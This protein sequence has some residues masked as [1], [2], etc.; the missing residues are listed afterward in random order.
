MFKLARSLLRQRVTAEGNTSRVESNDRHL[1]LHFMSHGTRP[2]Q[3][4][5]AEMIDELGRQWI[6]LDEESHV[7]RAVERIQQ[8]IP[9][10]TPAQFPSRN[11]ALRAIRHLDEIPKLPGYLYHEVRGQAGQ[12][13]GMARGGFGSPTIFVDRTDMYFGND[14]L[15]LV[16]EALMRRKAS[17]A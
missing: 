10:D 12:A 5:F 11:G 3:Y 15:P 16:R 14:R 7:D 17:A 2:S 8:E 9:I 6:M 4:H 1:P 13:V